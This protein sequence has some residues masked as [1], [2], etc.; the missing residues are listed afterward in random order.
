MPGLH[1]QE[2]ISWESAQVL[3]VTPS[4]LQICLASAPSQPH[5]SRGNFHSRCTTCTTVH[6]RPDLEAPPPGFQP[7]E[8]IQLQAMPSFFPSLRARL[9][10]SVQSRKVKS[11]WPRT[12]WASSDGSGLDGLFLGLASRQLETWV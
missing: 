3:A 1:S 10:F 8:A 9:V 4:R 11:F 2:V 7:Q 6:R 5:S 12:P